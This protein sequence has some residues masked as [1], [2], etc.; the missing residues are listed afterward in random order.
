MSVPGEKVNSMSDVTTVIAARLETVHFDGRTCG[1]STSPSACSVCYGPSPMSARE[2]AAEALAAIRE[3]N[4][5]RTEAELD[6]LPYNTI[7]LDGDG[8]VYVVGDFNPVNLCAVGE[9][10]NE[11][12]ELPATVLYRPI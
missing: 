10:R 4:T 6:A 11:P 2:I 8:D 9:P 3:A 1:D 7:L 12:P 5:I